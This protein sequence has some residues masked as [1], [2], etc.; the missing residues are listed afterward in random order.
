M[1]VKILEIKT[2]TETRE[3]LTLE[4]KILFL[5]SVRLWVGVAN[6]PQ[7]DRPERSKERVSLER[8]SIKY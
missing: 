8:L 7:G 2:K 5:F 6:R 4:K 3:S 1:V